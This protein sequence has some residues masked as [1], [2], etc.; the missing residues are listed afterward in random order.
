MK[1]LWRDEDAAHQPDLEGLLYVSRLT[2][3]DPSLVLWGGGN[4]SAKVDELDFRDR[5][6]RVL[7]V[8]GS[9][10][11]LRS[12]QRKDFPGVRLDDALALRSR[13]SMTDEA[14]V[15]YL[16]HTLQEPSS[17]RPSIETLLHAF[18][19]ARFV[20]HTHAD[21]I[22]MLTNSPGGRRWV[23]EALG[24]GALWV[25]YQRP[26]FALSRA[27]A[28][29]VEA[30]PDA[31]CVVLEKHGLITWGATARE[32]YERTVD[33]VTQAEL[34]VTARTTTSDVPPT[35]AIAC[36]PE[37]SE[38]PEL[39]AHHGRS[40]GTDASLALGATS[41]GSAM[42]QAVDLHAKRRAAYVKLAPLVRGLAARTAPD[43]QVLPPSQTLEVLP[44]GR[45]VLR[46]DDGDD[47]LAFLD[48][49]DAAQLSQIGP[50]T[51]DH[52]INTKRLPLYVAPGDDLAAALDQ[53]WRDW[54][55][56]YAAYVREGSPNTP[57]PAPEQVDLRPR[58]VLLAG[59]GMITL[60]RDARAA[61]VAG[62]IYRHAIAT[63]RGAEAVDAYASLSARDCYD[64]EF[65]PMELYK[66]TLAPPEK[67][68]A[69]RIAL[70]T[71]AASGI[72]RA[73]AERFAADGAHVAIGDVDA[74]A[75]QAV[76]SAIVQ[77]HGDGRAIA[78][79]M[80]VADESSV[81]AAFDATVAAFSGLDILVS[82]AGIAPYAAIEDT[83]LSDWQ[84]A[85]DVN[86]TGHFLAVREALRLFRRQGMGGNAIVISTKN[87][88]APG[89]EFGAYSASKS[90]QAQLARV[91][92]L[93]GGEIG[94]RVNMLN[95]DAVFRG[96]TL[97]SPELRRARAQAHGVPEAELGD[98]YRKRCLL[99][100]PIHPEDVAE[101]AWFLATDRSRKMSGGVITVDGGVP[102]AFP[103]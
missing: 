30:R 61:R 101:A 64:V 45:V 80:N 47:V 50:A 57:A 18:L 28:Q 46:W 2:G 36:G 55:A 21:A 8:K 3:A 86:S 65:W 96:S 93:E 26:G 103:R 74:H 44:Q 56:S 38:R 39:D 62:D 102:A 10:S 90:A 7:R 92:A 84:R 14:M 35:P 60:G 95:P 23:E 81:R 77:K 71:G 33:L 72:G 99:G 66:L 78:M 15:A 73:I 69:R 16:A 53:A 48:D 49:P 41:S 5:P 29:A 32:A 13:D 52:L 20:I 51:P 85:F 42:H 43:G 68:L 1:S 54:V 34:Y 76:A 19:P 31:T 63:I 89:K 79:Q 22:L 98:F 58:V 91:A 6:V 4:T 59:I 25:D 82:N 37:R 100:L 87:T 12:I 27:V 94:V 88:M 24:G 67:E 97:W 40:L 17:P 83:P 11:D 70:V 75:A 9:G